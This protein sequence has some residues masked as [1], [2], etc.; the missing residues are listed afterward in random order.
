[1]T[2]PALS[3]S[4]PRA[5]ARRWLGGACV[6]LFLAA[7]AFL[8]VWSGGWLQPRDEFVVRFPVTVELTK[9]SPVL[10]LGQPIGRVQD[11]EVIAAD[12]RPVV[13][14]RFWIDG[15][16]RAW[17]TQGASLM[18]RADLVGTPWLD[19]QPGPVGAAALAAGSMVPGAVEPG[20]LT[21]LLKL[22]PVIEGL[23]TQVNGL[24]GTLNQTVSRIDPILAQVEGQLNATEKGLEEIAKLIES[25]HGLFDQLKSDQAVLVAGVATTLER[26]NNDLLP[27]LEQMINDSRTMVTGTFGELDQTLNIVQSRL[28]GLLDTTQETLANTRDLT[29]ALNHTWPFSS[30]QKKKAKAEA[31]AAKKNAGQ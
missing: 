30:Y 14:V 19:L 9:S 4:N 20:M 24:V 28:P 16:Q 17:M 2:R 11:V 5:S 3:L 22:Q 18:V 8:A 21:E 10:L 6:A 23:I 29:E 12:G 13:E 31:A 27:G 25:S 1:M 26:V 15:A 7:L